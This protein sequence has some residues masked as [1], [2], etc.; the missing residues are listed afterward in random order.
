VTKVPVNNLKAL[1]SVSG[2]YLVYDADGEVIYIGQA[3]N[4]CQRWNSG[5]H[6]LGE[7]IAEC[8]MNA[9]ISWVEVPEW[10]LNRAENAAV[11]FYKPRLNL[12]TPSVV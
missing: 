3:K 9:Y 4:I 11:R 7:I 12:R 5:H 1:P 2:I 10:L 8:G 6:K